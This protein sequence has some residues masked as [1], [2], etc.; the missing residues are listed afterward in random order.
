M[1]SQST[2]ALLGSL[3]AIAS[4]LV[5]K[6]R[7]TGR[8]PAMGWNSWNEYECN[9]NES[10]FINVADNMISLGLA[11][12]GY[13]YVNID[14]CWSDKTLRRNNQTKDIVVDKKKFPN[15]IKGL[16][17]K[18]HKKG[19]KIGIYSDAGSLTCGG[20]EGSLG[21]ED[22][23]AATFAKWGID[24]RCSFLLKQSGFADCF[25]KISSTTIAMYQCRIGE[26]SIDG[27]QSCRNIGHNY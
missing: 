1:Y 5:T 13:E 6:D 22:I 17:Q 12:L 14:D 26:M 16:A 10:V 27:G 18:I 11:K 24:C 19:L 2:Y 9:I 15:G 25:M 21:Y 23:D 4:A 3:A 20:F 7:V 8:L